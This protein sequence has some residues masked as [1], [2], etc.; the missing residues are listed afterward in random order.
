MLR[1]FEKS[2]DAFCLVAVSRRLARRVHSPALLALGS[3]EHAERQRASINSFSVQLDGFETTYLNDGEWIVPGMNNL[4]NVVGN[5]NQTLALLA[6][7][8]FDRS[9]LLADQIQ[10][11]EL[12]LT[13]DLEIAR[14]TLGGKAFNLQMG[15]RR[16]VM[17][18]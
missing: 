4:G 17:I 11:P 9:R 16:M 14:G 1:Q 2:I 6:R 18:N 8:D 15:G 5:L 10:R 7:L 13:A 12:R 3:A